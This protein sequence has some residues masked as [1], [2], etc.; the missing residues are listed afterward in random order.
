MS[1]NDSNFIQAPLLDGVTPPSTSE[2]L[3]HLRRRGKK[4]GILFVSH[5]ADW[6]GPTN[7]LMLL[8]ENLRAT[9]DVAVVLP[10]KGLFSEVLAGEQIDFFT[11]PSLTKRSI[12]SLFRLIRRERISL[13]YGNTANSS[14]R[15][16]LVAAKLAGVP[17]ICHVRQMGWGKSWRQLGYLRLADCIVAVSEACAASTSK[18]VSKHKCRVIYNGVAS[19]YRPARHT[20]R[21]YL[22]RQANLCRDDFIIVDVGSVY[23]RKGQVYAVQAMTHIVERIPRARLLLVGSVDRGQAPVYV[24]RI[25]S[26]IDQMGLSDHV[27]LMDFRED[28]RQ[29]IQGA[30]LY[31]H[32]ALADPHPRAVIEAMSV[33]LPVVAFDVDGVSETV[34]HGDTGFL[35]P[36]GSIDRLARAVIELAAHSTLRAR[37]GAAGRRRVG[38]LFSATTTAEKVSELISETISPG[39]EVSRLGIGSGS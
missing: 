2:P 12:L 9:F 8:L 26:M 11:F 14:S 34:V 37:M 30:D 38:S 18:F 4:Q 27:S 1:R 35:I 22:L 13:V 25:H 39:A 16:A 33:G 5:T 20:A 21:P 7:S 28:T 3:D 36:Q 32:T 6:T 15:T 24:D 17:F 29:L 31:L 23:P 10:G 19:I